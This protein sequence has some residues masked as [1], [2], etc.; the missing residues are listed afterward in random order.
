VSVPA[1]NLGDRLY[2]PS[3][4]NDRWFRPNLEADFGIAVL[5]ECFVILNLWFGQQI[6]IAF[7]KYE[8]SG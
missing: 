8:E 1:R 4:L 7:A 6:L 3:K 2:K 5:F